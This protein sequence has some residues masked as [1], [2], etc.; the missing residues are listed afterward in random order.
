MFQ[1][2]P[3]GGCAS[4]RVSPLPDQEHKPSQRA[5]CRQQRCPDH[6]GLAQTVVDTEC[7]YDRPGHRIGQSERKQSQ[8]Q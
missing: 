8:K 2:W 5:A 4:V 6:I 1:E 7:P 3:T